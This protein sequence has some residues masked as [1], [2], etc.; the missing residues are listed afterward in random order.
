[1]VSADHWIAVSV[2]G[3][4][5]VFCHLTELSSST[6]RQTGN[7]EIFPAFTPVQNFSVGST[8]SQNVSFTCL[9]LFLF[10]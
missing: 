7:A 6:E 2:L 5:D 3:G 10:F 9:C 1:M 4:E 8:R